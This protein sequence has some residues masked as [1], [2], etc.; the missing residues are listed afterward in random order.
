[1]QVVDADLSIGNQNNYYV[2]HQDQDEVDQVSLEEIACN[3]DVQI[4]Q[5]INVDERQVSDDD[6]SCSDYSSDIA[7]TVGSKLDKNKSS[8]DDWFVDS[9]ATSHMTFDKQ[10]LFDYEEFQ[11][12]SKVYLGDR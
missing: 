11:E 8:K 1:M 12:P 3:N 6:N 5:I 9:A 4:A 10:I 2:E 7:L